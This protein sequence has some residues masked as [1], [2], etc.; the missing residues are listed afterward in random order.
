MNQFWWR[1]ASVLAGIYFVVAMLGRTGSY[2]ESLNAAVWAVAFWM[3]GKNC[4]ER[5][6]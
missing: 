2:M 6:E 3:F 1:I 4:N 5:S